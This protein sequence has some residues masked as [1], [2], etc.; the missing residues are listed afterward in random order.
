MK[1]AARLSL[2][3][4]LALVLSPFRSEAAVGTV[5]CGGVFVM[6]SAACAGTVV[7]WA[8]CVTLCMGPTASYECLALMAG[9]PALMC[10]DGS[11]LVALPDGQTKQ[12]SELRAGDAVA[13][14]AVDKG[15][16][17]TAHVV[18]NI[19]IKGPVDFVEVALTGGHAFNVTMDHVVVMRTSN[20]D[21]P[22]KL[23]PA[24]EVRVGDR[25]LGF[26]GQELAVAATRTVQK[27]TKWALGTSL[28]TATVNGVHMT[29]F[30]DGG[31]KDLPS[32]DYESAMRAWRSSHGQDFLTYG[33]F[34]SENACHMPRVLDGLF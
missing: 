14:S 22:L 4:V 8:A 2:A 12:V 29:A 13:V 33:P 17:T 18:E 28:G 34:P 1:L 21:D 10:Q 24:R 6:C 5:A 32:K 3:L 23:A 11:S 27:D 31:L 25:M 19:E 9:G 7:G 15:V 20:A 16:S 30:C 26:A